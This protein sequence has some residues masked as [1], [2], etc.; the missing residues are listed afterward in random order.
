MRLFPI[1]VAGVDLS[2]TLAADRALIIGRHSRA[3]ANPRTCVSRLRAP[4]ERAN[5]SRSACGKIRARHGRDH[6]H[7]LASSREPDRLHVTNGHVI[8]RQ[9][10][11]DGA[12]LIV[13]MHMGNWEL[14]MWPITL[15]GVRPGRG[16]PPGQEPLCQ[17]ATCGRSAKTSIRGPVRQP[18]RPWRGGRAEDGAADHG[19]CAL[20]GRTARLHLRPLR[21]ASGVEVPFFGYPRQ[22]H[23]DRGD[24]RAQGR[25]PHLDR[26]LRCGIGKARLLRHQRGIEPASRAPTI[27]RKTSATLPRRIQRHFRVLDQGKS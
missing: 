14:G 9:R 8:A 10:G 2:E 5:R 24:D 3:L 23:A 11:Q 12:V 18:P 21:R 13:T 6:E 17:I 4:E 26:A 20:S 16:L 27:R 1:D 22:E 25:R 7:R 15:A 19:L